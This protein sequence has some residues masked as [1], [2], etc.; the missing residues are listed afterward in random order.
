MAERLVVIGGDAAGMTAAA[1]A[2]RQRGELEIVALERGV[3][4]SYAACG[5]PF[6]VAGEIEDL[7]ALVAR[8]P[9]EF[10][11]RQRIDVRTRHEVV[12]IDTDAG[13][14]EVR[15]LERARTFSLGY[16]H[17]LIG[18]GARPIRPPWPGVD[19]PFVHSVHTLDDAAALQALADADH[20]DKVVVVG[21]GY[22][23]I[24]MAEAFVRWGVE[25][26]LVDIA[27]NVMRTMD[28]DMA[29]LIEQDIVRRGVELRTGVG[30]VGLEPG[31]VLLDDGELDADLVVLGIG[32]TPNADLARDAGLATGD[33]GAIRVDRRQQTSVEG[34]WAAGDCCESYHRVLERPVHVAL[35]TVANRQGRV[36]GINIG[37]GYATFPGVV[38]TAITRF[39]STEIARTGLS[40]HEAT[41]AGLRYVVGRVTSK[42][43]AHYFPGAEPITVKVLAE[44]GTARLLGAQIVGGAGAGKR[45]DTMATA[46]TAGFTAHEMVNLDLAY[47]PPFAPVWDPVVMAARDAL[48]HLYA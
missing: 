41:A 29:E 22:I 20:V 23:G 6:H 39:W 44:Q 30:V 12:A 33:R 48:R 31:K 45:I 42:T 19:L 24:E 43:K 17:L 47:A 28:P 46:I 8:T 3:R 2:R 32:V 18:T 26:T 36:A 16:D 37:G 21:G 4:T 1:T 38:G 27:P 40:E 25:C 5:I 11:D 13:T 34:V 10:R 9:Q 15:D 35:G 14:V 7:D